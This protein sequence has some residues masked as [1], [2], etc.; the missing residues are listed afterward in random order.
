[1]LRRA[2]SCSSGIQENGEKERFAELSRAVGWRTSMLGRECGDGGDGAG[3]DNAVAGREL[4][5]SPSTDCG[6]ERAGSDSSLGKPGGVGVRGRCDA[7]RIGS[8]GS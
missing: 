4:D 2:T 5:Q 3:G 1:M 7:V 6:I 8:T